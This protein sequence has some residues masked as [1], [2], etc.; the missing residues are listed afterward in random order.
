MLA[1]SI[2]IY[3]SMAEFY[4]ALGGSLEQETD[5]TIHSLEEIHATVPMKSPLFRTNYYSIVLIR[6]GNG[7]YFLDD[8][9]YQTKPQT[10][11]F[12]NPGHIKGF[13]VSQ[14]VHGYVITF[15]EVFL[16][17]YISRLIFDE[18]PF[19]IA[20]VLP[21]QYPDLELFQSFDGLGTQLMTEYR[22]T[23]P[24]KFKIVG[25]LLS[26]LLYK[27]KE[28]F[29]QTDNILPGSNQSSAIA[30]AFQHNL[31]AHFRDLI[32][33]KATTLYQVQDYAQAQSLHPSYLNTVI[34]AKTGK[35][36]NTWIAEKTI[37]EASALLSRSTATVM[38]VS[39]Q[40]GFKEPGHFSRFFK[41][42]TGITPS[43]FRNNVG[44]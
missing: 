22:S 10:I 21:P 32:A 33:N 6:A 2:E 3:N 26:V 34:K 13:E 14:L 5:F 38:Q 31:E 37:A 4:T 23:S 9:T 27:I 7:L 15:S 11:Y 29:W 20:E 30:I 12:N 28:T 1:E 17:Q 24:Y 36:V 44:F 40:L 41:K 16:K 25:N 8:R 42:H 18:F 35:S 39:A 19:L 43:E